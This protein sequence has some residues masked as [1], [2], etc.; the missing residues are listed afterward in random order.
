MKRTPSF[1]AIKGKEKTFRKER[2]EK[3]KH[4]RF[5]DITMNKQKAPFQDLN[6][7]EV[8]EKWKKPAQFELSLEFGILFKVR[9]GR[10]SPT[11]QNFYNLH[12]NT[13]ATRT[14][15]GWT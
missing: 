3:E 1:H 14:G 13:N 7:A 4:L 15:G 10:F 8:L 9:A 2:F 5:F 11:G 12:P 6:M